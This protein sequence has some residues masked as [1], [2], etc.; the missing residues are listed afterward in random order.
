MR[1]IGSYRVLIPP[2]PVT[3]NKVSDSEF[4]LLSGVAPWQKLNAVQ[5]FFS[6]IGPSGSNVV[7]GSTTGDT[8]G[9]S[10]RL[11]P[12]GYIIAGFGSIWTFYAYFNMVAA[13]AGAARIQVDVMNGSTNTGSHFGNSIAF[14]TQG[15]STVSFTTPT[16][17]YTGIRILAGCNTAPTVA[18]GN[19]IWFS[20]I[21][22]AQEPSFSGY[23]P[24]TGETYGG[25]LL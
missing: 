21:Y 24:S 5:T 11:L 4:M 18:S 19:K 12:P 20:Q 10:I 3:R 14:G 23:I 2:F 16:S 13:T 7:A 9:P 15:G 17:G 8:V 25:L 6:G 1:F 22:A